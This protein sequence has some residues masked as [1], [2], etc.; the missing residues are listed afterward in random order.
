MAAPPAGIR[1]IYVSNKQKEKYSLDNVSHKLFK[2]QESLEEAAT[3]GF[4]SLFHEIKADL[5]VSP[6]AVSHEDVCHSGPNK[7]L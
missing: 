3:L 2:K 4:Y 5:Q 6:L 7:A 1:S